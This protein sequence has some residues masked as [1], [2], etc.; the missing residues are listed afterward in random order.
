M[1]SVWKERLRRSR[2]GFQWWYLRG[3]TP[4]DRQINP[5]E[6]M[7]FIARTTPNKALDL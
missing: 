4:W 5:P 3:K 6:V 1:G 7:E 2:L